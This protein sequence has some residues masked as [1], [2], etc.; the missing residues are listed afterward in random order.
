MSELQNLRA[1]RILLEGQITA[2]D[3][4]LEIIEEKKLRLLGELALLN[5]QIVEELKRTEGTERWSV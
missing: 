5:E 4:E 1:Q 2:A 3:I